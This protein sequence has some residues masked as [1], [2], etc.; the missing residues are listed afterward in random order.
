MKRYKFQRTEYDGLSIAGASSVVVQKE[1]EY[2]NNIN[3]T[4]TSTGA[5]LNLSCKLNENN[6]LS[7]KNLMTGSADNKFI[8]SVG[9]NVLT[10]QVLTINRVNSRFFSAN[11]IISSQLNGDHYLPVPKIKIGFNVGL[12]DVVRTVPNLRFTSYNK[13][14]TFQDPSNPEP[15]DTVYKAE[16]ATSTGPAYSGYRVFSKLNES[17][18]SGKIDASRIFKVNEEIKIDT[19]IG[20][21]YQDRRRA[22]SIRQFGLQPYE[23]NTVFRDMDLT[24]LSEDKI[25]AQEHMGVTPNGLGGFKLDE[26]TKHPAGIVPG[27]TTWYIKVLKNRAGRVNVDQVISYNAN[28]GYIKNYEQELKYL[29]TEAIEGELF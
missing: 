18:K 6:S 20:G 4:Q 17:I 8:N 25:F 11:R 9:S 2:F 26:I 27:S 12:S 3:Q 29:K 13:F 15:S 19:K 28:Q 21:F 1:R 10:E 5:L 22:F 16:V 14:S 23:T 24:L 7:L